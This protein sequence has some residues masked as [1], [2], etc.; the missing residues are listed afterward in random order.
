MLLAALGLAAAARAH[1]CGERPSLRP[2]GRY[3]S[4]TS[5]I[6]AFAQDG[7]LLPRSSRRARQSVQPVVI[8][9]L[10][11]GRRQIS[12]CPPHGPTARTSPAAGPST[13]RPVGFALARDAYRS[14]SGRSARPPRRHSRSTTS[15]APAINDPTE[16]RFQELAHATRGAGAVARRASPATPTPSSTPSSRSH[17]TIRSPASRRR[18]RR[19]RASSRS[20]AAGSTA[21][22]DAS[23]PSS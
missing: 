14:R 13:P 6:S 3:R 22:S 5:L 12:P 2:S 16:R 21:S 8:L 18:S 4:L 9:D 10:A 19:T 15:S 1:G 20:P 17:T 11:H 23:R 7:P